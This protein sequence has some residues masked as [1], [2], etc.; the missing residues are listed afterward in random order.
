MRKFWLLDQHGEDGP[1]ALVETDGRMRVVQILGF[2]PGITE[3]ADQQAIQDKVMGKVAPTLK[4]LV[5]GSSLDVE[6]V[7]PH[8]D[9]TGSPKG[10]A[11][12]ANRADRRGASKGGRASGGGRA[13]G[14]PSRSGST[15]DR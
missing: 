3:L 6:S 2:G 8:A 1:T 5:D 10:G 7:E 15:G 12:K 11:K 14:G 4:P 9:L 13:A